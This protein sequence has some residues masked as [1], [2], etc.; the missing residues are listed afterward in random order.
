MGV[1]EKDD[2][3]DPQLL[4]PE[5]LRDKWA[6]LPRVELYQMFCAGSLIGAGV[7]ARVIGFVSGPRF[8]WYGFPVA[9][10]LCRL[11]KFAFGGASDRLLV[12][13]AER[14]RDVGA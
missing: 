11:Q 6:V 9:L 14:E 1:L 3:P 4:L 5:E 8:L 13:L 12:E 7:C 10:L 2:E